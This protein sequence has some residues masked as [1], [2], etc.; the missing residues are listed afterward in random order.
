MG[1]V[2]VSDTRGELA[3]VLWALGFVVVS[4]EGEGSE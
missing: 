1:T 3:L 2:R 4:E